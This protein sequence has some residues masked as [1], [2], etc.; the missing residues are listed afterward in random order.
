MLTPLVLGALALALASPVPWALAR[1]ARL[2]HTPVPT[3]LLWQSTALAAVLAAL[4]VGLSLLTHQLWAGPVGTLDV[5]LA[6]AG[7]GHQ[8][9]PGCPERTGSPGLAA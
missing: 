5:V 7:V 2:R 9:G 8:A 1:A 4:G 3:M 6:H